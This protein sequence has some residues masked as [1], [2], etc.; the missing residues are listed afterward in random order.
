MRISTGL[1]LREM[2][3]QVPIPEDS[4]RIQCN[5]LQWISVLKS[6]FAG[7]DRLEENVDEAATTCESFNAYLAQGWQS[8]MLAVLQT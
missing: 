8:K 2:L 4:S 1:S 6:V 3:R 7:Y 5:R